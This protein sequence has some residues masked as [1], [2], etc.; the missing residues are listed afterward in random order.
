MLHITLEPKSRSTT[1]RVVFKPV[2][3]QEEKS[4]NLKDIIKTGTMQGEGTVFLL[5]PKEFSQVFSPQRLKLLKL[6]RRQ[7]ELTIT[8]ISEDLGRKREAVSRD[9]RFFEGLGLIKIQK[10]SRARLPQRVVQE[11]TI[12]L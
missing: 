11:I 12:K 9:I 7:P 4:R 3:T 6:V 1:A 10:K 8:E 5:T 2:D